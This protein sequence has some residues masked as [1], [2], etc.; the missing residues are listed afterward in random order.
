MACNADCPVRANLLSILRGPHDLRRLILEAEP[1]DPTAALVVED[2]QLW[3][4]RHL[5]RRTGR[6]VPVSELP[7]VLGAPV[8]LAL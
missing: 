8:P 3:R 1:L 4:R 5:S 7:V 6:G 2:L